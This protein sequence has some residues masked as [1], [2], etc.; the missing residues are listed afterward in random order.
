MRGKVYGAD[1]GD[2]VK[3][4]FES[5]HKR[6]ELVH[7]TREV[8]HE[9]AG[10][11]PRRRGLHRDVEPARPTRRRPAPNYLSYYTDALK[12]NN[13]NYAVY[14]VDAMGRKA[15]DALGVLSHFDAVIWY[16]GNDNVTRTH[17]LG[18]RARTSSRTTSSS[19][20]ATS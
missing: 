15:P 1:P 4:W 12:A 13:I 20:C 18:R 10:A 14:D 8:G 17:N 2:T 11:D 7:A 9:R 6:S 16:T 19:P 3:V 5:R